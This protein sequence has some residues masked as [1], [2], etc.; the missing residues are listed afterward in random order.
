MR[1][2]SDVISVTCW[3][4]ADEGAIGPVAGGQEG[5]SRRKHFKKEYSAVCHIF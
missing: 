1:G 4:D 3:F 5:C 2:G